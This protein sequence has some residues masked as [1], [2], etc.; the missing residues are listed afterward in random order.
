MH[1]LL[2]NV[3]GKLVLL[4]VIVT[5]LG[6]VPAL[7]QDPRGRAGHRDDNNAR[8]N[9]KGLEGAW[10]VVVT[11]RDCTTGALG[12][13]FPGLMT[14][15]R[16]GVMVENSVGS[17]T[18]TGQPPTERS[19][20]QGAWHH[21]KDGVYSGTAWTFRFGTDNAYA[22]ASRS[23]YA[24]VLSDDGASFT[25]TE[26]AQGFDLA[27]VLMGTRCNSRTGTRIE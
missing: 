14:F 25:S 24:I 10:M 27:G 1:G 4:V 13:T 5:G 8:E 26:T 22:G 7:A 21:E 23:A 19:T 17:A 2:S 3:A 15:V 6:L 11:V 18:A 20:A 12:R 9:G 16:G